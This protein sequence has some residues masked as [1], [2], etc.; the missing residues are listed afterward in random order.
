MLNRLFDPVGKSFTSPASLL[1]PCHPVSIGV[2]PV[3]RSLLDRKNC[4]GKYAELAK[5][6]NTGVFLA[7]GIYEPEWP[8]GT[9]RE[10]VSEGLHGFEFCTHNQLPDES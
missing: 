9:D 3:R 1:A 6:G 5:H 10:S 4:K 7:D 8:V 2:G